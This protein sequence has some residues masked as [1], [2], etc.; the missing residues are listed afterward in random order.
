MHYYRFSLTHGWKHR[1]SLA[2]F[3]GMFT[4]G[5]ATNYT[6]STKAALTSRMATIKPGDTVTVTNGTYN[7][8]QLNFT[9]RNGLSTSAWMVLKAQT[10]GGVVFTDSTYLQ[11]S[12]TKLLIS[13]FKFANGQSKSND[14]IQFRNNNGVAANYCRLSNI[15]INNY[16]SDST[17]SYLNDGSDVENRWVS[18]YGTHNRVD[19][20]TF[21]NKFNAAP[22]VVVWYDNNTYPQKSTPTYHLIDSNY[23]NGRGYLGG[24]GGES[25]RVGTSVNSRSDG[26]NIVEHNLFEN[27]VQLD[28]EII[29]NKSGSNIYRYNTFRNHAGGITLRHG[30]YCQVYGNFFVRDNTGIGTQYGI[31]M[32]DKGHRVYNNYIENMVGNSNS[33]TSLRCPLILFNGVT[34]SYDTANPAFASKYFAADSCIVAFNSIVN[35][36]GGAGIVL[37]FN[38]DSIGAYK[39]TGI[40]VANNLIKMSKGQAAI[41]DTSSGSNLVTYK[42]EGNIYQASKG[43]GLAKSTGFTSKT[44][45]FGARSNGVLAPPSAVKD[46]AINTATYAGM[47][48]SLDAQGK[49]RSAIF[50]VGA[51]ESNGTGT[52]IAYPL[53]TTLVG[54]GKPVTV[55]PVKLLTFKANLVN[56]HLAAISWQVASEINMKRYELSR[57]NDGIS[58]ETLGSLAAVQK[59]SYQWTDTFKALQNAP[60][61]YRLK[62]I[63]ID[64]RYSYSPIISLYPAHTIEKEVRLFPNPIVNG[65]LWVATNQI[66]D[67][68]QLVITN[69]VGARQSST[70]A[71]AQLVQI[72]INGL[73]KGMYF[74]QWI[75]NG[76]VIATQ[77]FVVGQ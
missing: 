50:D 31:R 61:Y 64:G 6:V 9:N 74:L 54:A 37:G 48:A 30:R 43:V 10:L 22:T 12:A 42:A 18:I 66:C 56:N 71:N 2:L 72:P 20:C 16:N 11:F 52:V 65:Q 39:P 46:A 62:M 32:I 28:P 59:H 57:S 33:L 7:W 8:G 55:L 24:N 68:A 15:I 36:S 19:H 49:T 25:I 53:D 17:G 3:M 29:S 26:Y 75:R 77:P 70:Q 38:V 34:D 14:V 47:L 13:G 4:M 21:I 5:F 1:F 41:A 58:F 63:D 60:K 51:L 73:T 76:A 23:F 67:N 44:I 45:T 40:V 69:M 35:C 27:G